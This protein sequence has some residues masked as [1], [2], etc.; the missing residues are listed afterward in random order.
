MWQENGSAQLF[1]LFLL[2]QGKVEAT[3]RV[4]NM[5]AKM[6][7]EGFANRS[8]QGACEAECPVGISLENIVR[9]NREY[10]KANLTPGK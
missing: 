4:Q 10:L 6:D 5:V 8:V 2:P 9:M 7:K 3:E 1:Q